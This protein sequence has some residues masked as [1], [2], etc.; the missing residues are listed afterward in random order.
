MCGKIRHK[1][2]RA[3]VY[4]TSNNRTNIVASRNDL[5]SC[6]TGSMTGGMTGGVT[7]ADMV[8]ISKMV[9]HL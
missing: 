8:K 1:S 7:G 9:G 3:R 6:E 4:N 2:E 5:V